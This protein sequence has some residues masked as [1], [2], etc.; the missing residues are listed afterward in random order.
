MILGI[1]ICYQRW[2]RREDDTQGGIQLGQCTRLINISYLSSTIIR[3]D[4]G[5]REVED[6]N[7]R[8]G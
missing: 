1:V 7:G 4:A 3:G 5:L 6:Y 2:L 8:T